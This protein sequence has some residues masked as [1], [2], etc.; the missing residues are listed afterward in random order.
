MVNI[1]RKFKCKT[2]KKCKKKQCK[3]TET[4]KK[5]Q[6]D[7]ET[8]KETENKTEKETQHD[9]EKVVLDVENKVIDEVCNIS[10][11][12]MNNLKQKYDTTGIFKSKNAV[13]PR[14]TY[15]YSYKRSVKLPTLSPSNT[16]SNLN[17]LRSPFTDRKGCTACKARLWDPH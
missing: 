17:A 5:N 15:P 1:E 6:T 9:V 13:N 11:K 3:K 12:I 8:E 2:D 4:D 16:A 10:Q 7:K 14:L